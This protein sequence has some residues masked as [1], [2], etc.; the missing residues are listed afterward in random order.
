MSELYPSS[1]APIQSKGVGT[2]QASTSSA[3]ISVVPNAA[4]APGDLIVI[5]AYVVGASGNVL[6]ARDAG[7]GWVFLDRAWNTGTNTGIILAGC[8][9]S[10][11]TGLAG[12]TLPGAAAWTSQSVTFAPQA[13]TTG[14]YVS[15][16]HC[17]NI[18]KAA[19]EA[20]NGNG[21]YFLATSSTTSGYPKTPNFP[22]SQCL[23]LIA[24]GCTSTTVRTVGAITGTTEVFDT[25]NTSPG[26]SIVLNFAFSRGNRQGSP[27]AGVAGTGTLSGNATNKLGVRALIPMYGNLND[28][29]MAQRTMGRGVRSG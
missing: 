24:R 8:Y 12:I 20:L 15:A 19:G 2:I 22:G 29:A 13:S 21:N 27:G 23:E 14:Q 3:T 7:N 26:H 25:G 4:T 18:H 10:R 6:N 28:G 16:R 17:L 1:T 11:S 9:A 5:V